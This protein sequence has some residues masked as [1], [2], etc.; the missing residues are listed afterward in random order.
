MSRQL[1]LSER[2]ARWRTAVW[3]MLLCFGVTALPA[4]ARE[5]EEYTKEWGAS[6]GLNS[7]LDDTNSSIV[8]NLHG[9]MGASVRFLFNPRMALRT[10]MG[11][12]FIGGDTGGVKDFY[13]D[14]VDQVGTARRFYR[15]SGTIFDLAA[16]Y[17][18]NFFSYA[19]RPGYQGHRRFTPYLQMGLGFAFST[20]GRTVTPWVPLGFGVKYKLRPQLNV[21]LDWTMRFS[22]SDRL[23]GFDAPHGLKSDFFR[24]QDHL[25]L[26]R[27]TI[28]YDFSPRCPTCNKAD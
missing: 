23:D 25:G 4:A 3:A 1:L 22:L 11:V 27:V 6:L 13:P 2:R 24:N 10:E 5:E 19:Y 14:Y 15:H 12:H 16:L 20:T 18:L 9:S 28:T 17:E 7:L 26:L 8:G 21:E